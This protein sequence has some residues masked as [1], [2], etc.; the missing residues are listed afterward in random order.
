MGRGSRRVI[1]GA[2]GFD[3]AGC[4]RAD[5]LLLRGER[6]EDGCLADGDAV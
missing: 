3:C 6:S 5:A 4:E 2:V 1:G